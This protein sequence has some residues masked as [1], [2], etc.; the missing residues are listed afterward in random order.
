M[1][2]SLSL[3]PLSLSPPPLPLLS[4]SPFSSPGLLSWFILVICL[5][6]RPDGQQLAVATL[7]GHLTF[8]D[9]KRYTIIINII[10]LIALHYN[11]NNNN[12][13][14]NNNN[15]NNNNNSSSSSNN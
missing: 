8:W 15:N 7:N 13:N 1:F 6:Y 9:V 5:S 4:P 2:L 3:P 14:S 12:N 10:L 11:N